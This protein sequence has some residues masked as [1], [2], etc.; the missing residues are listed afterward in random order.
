MDHEII[1]SFNHLDSHQDPEI[2]KDILLISLLEHVMKSN[3]NPELFNNF[4]DFLHSK[5]IIN[6]KKFYSDKY[7]E[8]RTEY[9]TKLQG[10][11]GTNQQELTTLDD[12]TITFY[13]SRYESDFVELEK[14]NT[15]GFGSV[16]KATNKLDGINL[17]N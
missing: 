2:N 11:I 17:C 10:L 6:N 14:I 4:C 8:T 12:Q 1:K 9:M 5:K 3:K 7:A 13:Q 15:G 16:H